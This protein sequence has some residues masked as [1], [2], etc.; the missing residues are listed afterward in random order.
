MA[1]TTPKQWALITGAG[2]GIG[3]ALAH[4]MADHGYGI[5]LMGRRR[6]PLK[7]TESQILSQH[8]RARTLILNTD[9][10]QQSAIAQ[11][12]MG[13]GR[14]LDSNGAILTHLVHCAGTGAPES[15]S[16]ESS[17]KELK[18]ALAVN[19][20]APLALTQQL[21]ALLR[22][23]GQ[24]RVMFLGAGMDEKVQPGTGPYGISKMALKRLFRQLLVDREHHPHPNNPA[25]IFYQP[26]MVDTPG[27]RQHAELAAQLSL[28]HASFLQ[29]AL[30]E[31][32]AMPVAEA[33]RRM[34]S[35][36]ENKNRAEIDG[37]EWH[38]RNVD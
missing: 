24:G 4:T 31:G 23:S 25:L 3:Q 20:V 9:I 11:A 37:K 33:A 14:Y 34:A 12:V 36:L 32:T 10:T 21:L 22:Q 17:T 38:G 6:G 18:Q 19:A 13:I 5:I 30:E 35:L 16:L 15:S 8:P 26:G 27:L 7:T 2:S 29:Q 28:P 1:T